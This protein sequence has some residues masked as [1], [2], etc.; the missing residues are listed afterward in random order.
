VGGA[1]G[2]G[3]ADAGDNAS[4]LIVD[5][6]GATQ[7]PVSGA[8]DE[9]TPDTHASP[10]NATPAALLAAGEP[11]IRRD[12]SIFECSPLLGGSYLAN[13]RQTQR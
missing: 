12:L 10:R 6:L 9:H 4:R 5:T 3:G 11:G 1:D 2:V 7:P 8:N 13:Q